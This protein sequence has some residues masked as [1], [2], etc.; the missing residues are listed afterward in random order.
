MIYH[1]TRHELADLPVA[2]AVMARG[3]E[4]QAD[5]TAADARAIFRRGETLVLPVLDGDRYLGSVDR[6]L[7]GA[8]H[9][10]A[11]IIATLA[12]AHVPVATASTP[13]AEALAWLD[14]HGGQRLVVVA[15]DDNTYVGIVCLRTDRIRLCVDARCV[16]AAVPSPDPTTRKEPP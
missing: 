3:K 12:T 15:D 11:T 7:L 9:D 8:D 10:D 14:T 13:T 5:A 1:L 2:S 4:L 6:G 16:E